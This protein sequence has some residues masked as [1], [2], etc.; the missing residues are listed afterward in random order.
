MRNHHIPE[1]VI[2]N[3]H[4][5]SNVIDGKQRLSC[6]RDFK[7]GKDVVW[8]NDDNEK[9][10]YDQLSDDEKDIFDNYNINFQVYMN[11][12]KDQEREIFQI[13]NYGIALSIGEKF[14]ANNHPIAQF[15][16]SL[17]KDYNEQLNNY[18]MSDGRGKRLLML[19][20]LYHIYV[21]NDHR[22]CSTGKPIV[23]WIDKQVNNVKKNKLT[24]I[25]ELYSYVYWL[26]NNKSDNIDKLVDFMF[27][28]RNDNCVYYKEW[29]ESK[30]GKNITKKNMDIR[31]T[32]LNEYFNI[33]SQ[34]ENKKPIPKAIRNKCWNNYFGK[35]IGQSLCPLCDTSIS[36]QDFHASHIKS[37]KNGGDNSENNL[38][39]LCST[40]N[41]SMSCKNMNEYIIENNITIRDNE[42]LK[43]MI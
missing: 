35:S 2:S 24:S 36:Q 15:I 19:T 30:D 13:V 31:N 14:R 22:S 38:I 33:L 8:I 32:I 40:C 17:D 16:I 9:K 18:I 25:A 6:L 34:K 27:A 7:L 26:R 1:I 11:I 4:G 28:V 43:I 3:R 37:R 29:K 41:T 42:K 39:P 12:D 23:N 5:L 20:S 21:D 10:K